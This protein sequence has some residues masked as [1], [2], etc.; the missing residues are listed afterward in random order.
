MDDISVFTRRA[1]E[2]GVVGITETTEQVVIENPTETKA[3]DSG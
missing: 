1:V 3:C 2:A